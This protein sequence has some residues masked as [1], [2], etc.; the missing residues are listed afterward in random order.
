MNRTWLCLLVVMATGRAAGA[1]EVIP[2]RQDRPPGP[3]L[4]PAE[5][6]RKMETPPGFQVQLFAS[7][8]E[9]V[10]PVAMTFDERGRVWV[11]E[12]V[13]YPRTSAG[14][15][16]D[17]LK[18]LED[19][20]RD[21]K[22]DKVTIFAE[23]LNIPS[24]I[25]L[26]YG[27]AFVANAPDLL[28]LKDTGGDGRADQRQVL[29]TGF[30]RTDTHELPN[31]LTWGP[32]GWL[33]G[34]NGVF[35]YCKIVHQGKT[36]EFNCALWR[37]HPKTKAFELFCEGTSN[38]WG[39]DY[40]ERGDFFV[41]A[42]VIDHLWHLTQTG[43][44]H[45]QAG[46]YPPF[47]WKIESIVEHKHQKAAYCGLCFYDA[48]VYPE[49]YRGK[50]FMGNI[51]GGCVNSDQ[52]Q[53]RGASYFA[54]PR[55]DFLTAN[56]AWFMPV[57]QKV[58]PDGCIWV[59]DWYDRYH[60]YQD[61]RR[62]PDGIDRGQGR[63]Y[64]IVY[65][66]APVPEAFDLSERSSEDLATMLGHA[67]VYYRRWARQL[68]IERGG[69]DKLLQKIV[70]DEAKPLVHR[71][72][73]LWTLISSAPLEMDMF[74]EVVQSKEPGLRAWAVRGAAE[75]FKDLDASSIDELVYRA[76]AESDPSVRVQWAIAARNLPPE[77]A[78]KVLVDVL[79]SSE[80][81]DSGL[82]QRIVW[83]NLLPLF[84]EHPD[85]TTAA[86]TADQALSKK[87]VELL[88]PRVLERLLA[89]DAADAALKRILEICLSRDGAVSSSSAAECLEMVLQ[90]W[91]N[92]EVDE[93]D[94]QWIRDRHSDDFL[95]LA[96]GAGDPRSVIALAF[97][98]S[99]GN[100]ST[101]ADALALVLD[102]RRDRRQRELMARALVQSG[103]DDCLHHVVQL[104]R[105]DA[106]ERHEFQ[107]DVLSA[108]SRSPSPSVAAHV[109]AAFGELP[110]P[111]RPQTLDL[112]CSRPAWAE[113]L[114]QAV[115]SQQVDKASL[116][117]NQ[118]RRLSTLPGGALRA[119]V[120]KIWGK[121]R[122]ERNPQR[123][124][125]VAQMH[126]VL[127]NGKGNPEE[128]AKVFA[129][130]CAQCHKLNGQ[131][132]E[133]GPD[134]TVNGRG[135]LDLLLSNLLD[136]NLVI[137]KDYQAYTAATVD[138]RVLA[139]LLVE[140]SQE[141]IVLKVAGGKQEVIPRDDL[142]AFKQSNLSLMPE[143]L[144]KQVDEQQFRDLIAYLL[145]EQP[146]ARAEGN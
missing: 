146:A 92:G 116:N 25:A 36:H 58:G 136:P 4:T 126:R 81:D 79:G 23:G 139:G 14:E 101:A 142:E 93:A 45:R 29:V 127:R 102:R 68:L 104:L 56:D 67:N 31:C 72:E 135:S 17:R 13:E 61:A 121:V 111:L 141:R 15:G 125:V 51:H 105:S 63:L 65:Q 69:M 89:H 75:R 33:Y 130:V 131:G 46:P 88:L 86:M 35:N 52:L 117:G 143:D 110:E 128:G 84:D 132:H 12:S 112:L 85:R 107:L 5:A 22:A 10:N 41:S 76:Q 99:L 24:G 64:R 30:G 7:E 62:D 113:Q 133:V 122:T 50:L 90:A 9:I 108:L 28:F 40:N 27:G 120:E 78:L 60:C 73:A 48:D 26:G 70:L 37:Y 140:D 2:H 138:G 80:A 100:P 8:P 53:P 95:E 47:T 144:E 32:D 118:L 97:T 3:P 57:A 114:V 134:L 16:K 1:A 115:E 137:G 77:S 59:L 6:L 38:P 82:T 129:K 94:R 21:G 11:V 74:D 44:Y 91:L 98:V 55:P 34:L 66:N 42:C 20:D 96:G 18:I 124:Q 106:K 49:E 87:R 39:L 103:R 109:L 19:V 145:Q 71:M 54:T 119:R 43:Y 83:R 123:E